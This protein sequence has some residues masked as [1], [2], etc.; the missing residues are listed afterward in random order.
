MC[1]PRVGRAAQ[2]NQTHRRQSVGD[3]RE[4]GPRNSW[5][6]SSQAS[7]RSVQAYKN[8][9]K[10]SFEGCSKFAKKSSA[11]TYSM[12]KV[13][14]FGDSCVRAEL[15][16]SSRHR[17]KKQAHIKAVGLTPLETHARCAEP[18]CT[19]FAKASSEGIWRF[20]KS[21][22]QLHGMWPRSVQFN[23]PSSIRFETALPA[24]RAQGLQT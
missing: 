4:S 9:K 23:S 10:C 22:M 3:D 11:G 7:P 1:I 17:Q 12:C 13:G 15:Q 16:P 5:G 6:V 14:G 20:C 2:S 18:G 8:A 24:A 21:H 19:R